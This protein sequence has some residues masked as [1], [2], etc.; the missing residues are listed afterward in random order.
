MVSMG[1]HTFEDYNDPQEMFHI[2]NEPLRGRHMSWDEKSLK[3]RDS[4]QHALGFYDAPV[5]REGGQEDAAI[6]FGD[7]EFTSLIQKFSATVFTE[8]VMEIQAALGPLLFKHNGYNVVP[9]REGHFMFA[10]KTLLD[11]AY[12][13]RDFQVCLTCVLPKNLHNNA[14]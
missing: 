6:M 11:A 13:H 14:F 8:A 3:L 1:I 5:R 9:Q 12:F 4:T 7:V 10:F 2:F